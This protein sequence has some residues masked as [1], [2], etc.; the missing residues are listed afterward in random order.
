MLRRIAS[1]AGP[2][3]AILLAAST[4]PA[5]AERAVVRDKSGDVW[6]TS[7]HG[8]Y[9]KAGTQVNTDLTRTRVAH[10]KRFV[11]ITADYVKLKK[12]VSE[13]IEFDAALRTNGSRG[14]FLLNVEEDWLGEWTSYQ[15]F[16]WARGQ[17]D[18]DGLTGRTRFG[19]DT[20]EVRIPRSCLGH[21]RWI[22]F[23]GKTSSVIE[24]EGIYIDNANGTKPKQ[25]LVLPKAWTRRLHRAER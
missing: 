8:D 5:Q 22:R 1:I 21:P 16:G 17:V 20:L 10:H 23:Q 3:L 6:L 9:A 4:A 12:G 13:S 19:A 7:G 11:V 24:D 14:Y 25:S 18:C 15:L 2:L